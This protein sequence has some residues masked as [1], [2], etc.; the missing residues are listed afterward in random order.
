MGLMGRIEGNW[1]VH[2]DPTNKKL[3]DRGS[4][5]IAERAGIPYDEACFELHRTILS[6]KKAELAG[7]ETT[8]S[9]VAA[10]IKRLTR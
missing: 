6:L 8:L 4:R 2:V 5:I 7:E 3:I 1:M 9:P 10:A